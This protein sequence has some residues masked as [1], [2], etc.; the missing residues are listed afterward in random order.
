MENNQI[1]SMIGNAFLDIANAIETGSFGKKVKVGLTTVGS[2]LGTE[3]LVNGA[4]MAAKDG[5]FDVVII[6]PKVETHLEVIETNCEV[7]A[8]KIMEELIDTGKIAGCV[9]LHYSFDI[10]TSTVGRVITP[11]Y[12]TE[13][14]I[15]TTTGTSD[16]DRTCGMIKNAV[17]GIV[18]AKALGIEN[19]TVGILNVDNAR[20]V[21]RALKKLNENGYDINFGT[22]GR[23]DGG[24]VLRGNDIM[25]GSVDV[26]VTDSLTG[27]ILMKL[28]SSFNTGGKFEALGYGYGPGVAFD[29]KRIINIISRASGAPVVANALKYVAQLAQ[30]DLIGKIAKEYA[31]VQKAGLDEILESFKVQAPK[32]EKKDDFVAPAKEVV[33]AEIGGID[34]LDLDDAVDSVMRAGIYAESGMGCTGPL[35]L[36]SDS[37][38]EKAKAVLKENDII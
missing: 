11:A 23:A 28:L 35:L 1:K 3:N 25:L 37:N 6:G 20:G 31:E 13:M 26:M 18:T 33:T 30:G 19:P 4:E 29:A 10:G 36:V 12:G 16:T 7:E 21:E 17:Y 27:N 32:A 2:E 15:S 34:I 38:L 8:A 14:L 5:M 9:T 24:S 22:S